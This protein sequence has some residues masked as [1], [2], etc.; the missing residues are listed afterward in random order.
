MTITGIERI[1]LLKREWKNLAKIVATIA[2]ELFNIDYVYVFGSTIKDRVSGS[3]DLDIAVP[4]PENQDLLEAKLKIVERLY[5]YLSE[6]IVQILDIHVI[7]VDEINKPPYV[8]YLRES[9]IIYANS[10]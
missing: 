3:S 6:E 4:L 2:K 1:K 9:L 7:P 8:W 5:E 10:D